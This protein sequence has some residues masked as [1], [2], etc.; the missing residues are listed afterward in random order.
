MA[1]SLAR[2]HGGSGK[3]AAGDNRGPL[4]LPQ[5]RA[6]HYRHHVAQIRS[7]AETEQNAALQ[8][9]AHP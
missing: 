1:H 2:K 6:A 3:T 8:S 5:D 9:P 4:K 7:L